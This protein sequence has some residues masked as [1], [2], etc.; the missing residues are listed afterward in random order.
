[1]KRQSQLVLDL[2]QKIAATLRLIALRVKPLVLQLLDL[3]Q[4]LE[5]AMSEQLKAVLNKF[6][7]G[8]SRGAGLNEK[9]GYRKQSDVRKE[10]N[11]IFKANGFSWVKREQLDIAQG[12]TGEFKWSLENEQGE[13]FKPLKALA[14]IYSQDVANL[15]PRRGGKVQ[16]IS[17]EQSYNII[18]F[19]LLYG[20]V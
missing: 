7:E 5:V 18:K 20:V 13:E 19:A 10:M 3:E 12:E 4:Q 16:A 9:N 14:M 8:V 11:L 2:K 15:I 6:S 1:M 17:P